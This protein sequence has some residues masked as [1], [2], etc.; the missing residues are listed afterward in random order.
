A[1]MA[2]MA[3]NQPK[4]PPRPNDM[5]CVK[6][7]SLDTINK[8]PPNMAQFTVIRGKKIPN[9]LYNEGEYFSTII[10]TNWTMAAMTEMNNI[11]LRKVRSVPKIP[12]SL[13]I[14]LL[15]NQFTG[16]VI[17]CTKITASPKPKAVFTDFDTARK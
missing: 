3:R 4:P 6:L 10:S 14:L 8:E 13:K 1:A 12:F 7:Y 16:M 5:D 17:P 15:M 2:T 9:E 11:N